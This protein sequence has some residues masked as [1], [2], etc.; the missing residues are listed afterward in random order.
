MLWYQGESDASPTAAPVFEQKWRE[1]IQSVRAD[2]GQPDLPVYYVQIGRFVADGAFEH[3]NSV[4]ESQRVVEAQL[5]RLYM[6]TCIDC[7]LDDAIHV[8]TDDYRKLA[9]RMANLAEAK[10]KRG[11]RPVTA[12]LEGSIIKV[13]F[14]YVNERLTHFGRLNGFVVVDSA[15]KPLPLIYRQRV[16]AA[17]PNVVELLIGGRLPDGAMLRYGMTRDPY[18]NLVDAAGMPAPVFGPFPIQ[19]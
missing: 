17:D 5:D 7:E 4:Q 10:V 2:F 11:P 19:R 18:A 9:L 12:R 1:F 13:D 15:N 16:S 3:W 6:T 14:A 8:G